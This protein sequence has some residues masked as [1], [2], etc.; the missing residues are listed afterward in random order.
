MRATRDPHE[1]VDWA[2]ETLPARDV[3]ETTARYE[4][5]VADGPDR[6][7]RFA[8]DGT[9]PSRVLAGKSS[10]CEMRL[11]DPSASRRHASFYITGARLRVTDLGSTNG[12]YV[13]GIAVVDAFLDGGEFVRMGQT[14]LH[15]Q[16]AER[17]QAAAVCARESFGRV[18]G[19]SEQMRR[20]YPLCEKLTASDVPVIIE[21]ETG[22]GKELL[23]EAIHEASARCEGPFV[24]FDCMAAPPTLLE[25]ALFGHEKGAFTGATMS[26]AGVFERAHKGTLLIDEIGDLDVSLQPK[27]LRAIQRREVQRV[28]G[29][30]LV[31]VDVRVMAATR[32]DLDREVQAGRF[33]DDLYF[34]LNV[35]R[36]ELPPL[37]QRRGDI[38]LLARHF[39]E[40]LGG[41][42][43]EVPQE[44]LQRFEDYGWPGNV[45]ELYNAV[46]RHIALGELAVFAQA[47]RPSA[48]PPS[49]DGAGSSDRGDFL[50]RVLD[51]GLALGEARQQVL[52]EFERRYLERALADHGGNVTKAAAASGVARRYFHLLRS[53][54]GGREP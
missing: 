52:E 19:A 43:T 21:G 12:T 36:V 48:P 3:V 49:Q 30:G 51:R 23:A 28:G 29:S 14:T 15:V 39:W 18:L 20:L 35:A 40:E 31:K 17:A 41:A 27:L 25:S 33:R 37:R 16:P 34:R 24:V 32:R 53:K 38:S 13:N 2:T 42:G 50:D 8:L 4:L 11:S 7:T 22:T 5:V 44:L 10:S 6:G 9:S 54:R 1:S 45:R 46:A 26:R 47:P